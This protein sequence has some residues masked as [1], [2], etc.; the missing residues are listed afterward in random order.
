MQSHHQAD[1]LPHHSRMHG[2]LKLKLQVSLMV[3]FLLQPLNHLD[4]V[5]HLQATRSY[6]QVPL[7]TARNCNFKIKCCQIMITDSSLKYTVVTIL[8][9]QLKVS[10]LI[11]P[12]IPLTNIVLQ[13]YMWFDPSFNL[14]SLPQP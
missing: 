7:V 10:P 6:F 9:S 13:E 3:H 5:T 11:L 4:Q 12:S 1:D 2:G 14:V 8:L